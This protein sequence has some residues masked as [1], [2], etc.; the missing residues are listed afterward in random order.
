MPATREAVAGP[1]EVAGGGR[2]ATPNGES[3]TGST[4]VGAGRPGPGDPY[5][6]GP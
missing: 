2:I 4:A 1:L 3:G 6:I 5:P